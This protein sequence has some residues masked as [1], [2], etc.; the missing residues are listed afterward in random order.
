M[1]YISLIWS[2]IPE[3]VEIIAS[4]FVRR[5]H[6]FVDRYEISVSQMTTDMFPLT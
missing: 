2:Y 5:H 1:K 6:D 3:H 4:K